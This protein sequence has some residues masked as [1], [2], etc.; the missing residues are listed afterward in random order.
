METKAVEGFD[1]ASFCVVSRHG[2]AIGPNDLQPAE[3]IHVVVKSTALGK[4][5]E[6]V[7]RVG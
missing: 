4:V 2:A 3:R 5:V 6:S 7:R 1:S